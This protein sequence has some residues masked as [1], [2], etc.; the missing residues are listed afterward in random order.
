MGGSV[1]CYL[2]N[3]L[4]S[5]ITTSLLYRNHVIHN[6][7]VLVPKDTFKI[8]SYNVL[9]KIYLLIGFEIDLFNFILLDHR[10]YSWR[11]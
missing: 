5:L 1:M 3:L 11:R 4:C 10:T 8:V 9:G 7:T 2:I 6:G